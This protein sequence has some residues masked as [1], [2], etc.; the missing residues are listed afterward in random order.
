MSCFCQS[1]DPEYVLIPVSKS[2]VC[3][4]AAGSW[5]SPR[6]FRTYRAR[7]NPT[8]N[9]KIWEAA[10]ATTASP[11]LFKGIEI[12]G[13]GLTG[14]HFIDGG[15]H[16]NNPAKEVVDEARKV[17]GDDRHL[18]VLISI[19]TG[20]PGTLGLPKPD[21]FQKLLPLQLIATLEN[22]TTD[23]E[24][25]ASGLQQQYSNRP[26]IYLRFNVD[27]GVGRVSLEEWKRMGA[28]ATHTR[29]YLEDPIVSR[30]LDAAVQRL[31]GLSP[32]IQGVGLGAM[33]GA[34]PT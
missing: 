7:K 17:F 4:V 25:V 11:L 34:L 16:Y 33:G 28:V 3:A 21:A 12:A 14:E 31:C 5:N 29:A 1:L 9:C 27:H 6:R 20:H 15:L 8:V 22:V 23:C 10:R 2:L 26:D 32:P 19:G 30:S 18:G 24:S 13:V